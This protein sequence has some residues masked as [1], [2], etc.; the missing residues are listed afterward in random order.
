MK[1]LFSAVFAIC[2]VI[3]AF[4]VNAES[5]SIHCYNSEA[6]SLSD[7][8]VPNAAVV[9]SEAAA[10]K[11]YPQSVFDYIAEQMLVQNSNIYVFDRQIAT[12]DLY[13]VFLHIRN[14]RPELFFIGNMY[15]YSTGGAYV[16]SITPQYNVSGEE[17]EKA[18]RF[19]NS[20]L[21]KI[22]KRIPRSASTIEKA[23]LAH[24]YIADRCSYDMTLSN[25]DAYTML[26][27]NK[28]VC[29]AYTLLFTAVMNKLGIDCSYVSSDKANHIWNAVKLDDGYY[30]HLDVTWDD[31]SNA[32]LVLHNYFLVSTETVLEGSE[33]KA[34]WVSP[35]SDFGTDKYESGYIWNG[36]TL[37]FR[38]FEDSI[39]GA[40][41]E[42][43]GLTVY[44]YSDDMK[45]S[46]EV[47]TR[48]PACRW[49]VKDNPN[50][51]YPGF[52]SGFSLVGD[53]FIINTDNSIRYCR[54][55]NGIWV[56]G[57]IPYEKQTDFD[58]YYSHFDE[59]GNIILK[60]GN[61]PYDIND[62]MDIS[63][64][65]PLFAK[66]GNGW[67]DALAQLRKAIMEIEQPE[68]NISF[69]D[70]NGNDLPDIIDLVRLKKRA[71]A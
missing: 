7:G 9:M 63:V 49:K 48:F 15:N 57:V 62:S 37:P 23:L 35:V 44:R 58:F 43:G 45:N 8:I 70:V 38:C 40:A 67:A 13:Y 52:F 5:G 64:P 66:A 26:V 47:I 6:Y 20:E 29:Q 68:V 11:K 33:D 1:K 3:S 39:Y 31:P 56:S 30:Y 41:A 50:Y 32:A 18:M 2:F 55:I 34:D 65:L 25:S 59:N 60:S 69:L 19:Y 36:A 4:S 10:A 21:E 53:T 28:G 61:S 24:D 17:Y 46:F 27:E 12:A 54:K 16:F 14:S 71:A 22:V 51:S 42:N